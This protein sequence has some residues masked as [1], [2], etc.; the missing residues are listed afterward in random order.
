MGTLQCSSDISEL[1]IRVLYQRILR[2]CVCQYAHI[3]SLCYPFPS[4]SLYEALLVK[5]DIIFMGLKKA[6]FAYCYSQV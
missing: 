6:K 3:M 1:R 5:Q 2:V 4:V